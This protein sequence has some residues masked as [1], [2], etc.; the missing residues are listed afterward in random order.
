MPEPVGEIVH[1]PPVEQIH[2]VKHHDRPNISV[3]VQNPTIET[4]APTEANPFDSMRQ[5]MDGLVRQIREGKN[6]SE[7]KEALSGL[8][9]AREAYYRD[10]AMAINPNIQPVEGNEHMYQ[11]GDTKIYG[12]IT[13]MLDAT[14]SLST[15]KKFAEQI[16]LQVA[17]NSETVMGES[18][19]PRSLIESVVV[20]EGSN[21]QDRIQPF[22]ADIDMDEY[23]KIAAPDRKT[24]VHA[25]TQAL[26]RSALR[27]VITATPD[28][29]RAEMHLMHIT[30]GRHRE[31]TQAG[32]PMLW[33]MSEIQLGYK[34]LE[35]AVGKPYKYTLQEACAN[36]RGLSADYIGVANKSVFSVNK[37]I[38]VVAVD[39]NN[40]VLIDTI[41]RNSKAFQ[42]V[43]FDDPRDFHLLEHT[44]DPDTFVRY[45]DLMTNEV[46]EKSQQ[47]HLNKMKMMKRLYNLYKAKGDLGNAQELSQFFS[48]PIAAIYQL[49]SRYKLGREAVSRGIMT[50]HQ[51]QAIKENLLEVLQNQDNPLARE[52]ETLLRS[53]LI[54][55]FYEKFH[56]T[57]KQL[58]NSEIDAFLHEKPR[59]QSSLNEILGKNNPTNHN[60]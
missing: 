46:L 57:V 20:Y 32:T 19:Q 52:A 59:I 13:A 40:Q 39:S 9:K 35:D 27:P 29:Q 45:I 2:P 53:P 24:A 36:P 16:T 10:I 38:D 4:P 7:S 41:G 44:Y 60:I 48:S 56:S 5:T 21:A 12:S 49:E 25:L 26:Q 15:H 31:G 33:N 42:Q 18:L 8:L 1:M 23:V 22:A 14:P 34:M 3:E 6:V 28:G 43:F 17:G 30:L 11:V 47:S 58:I 54:H 50:G 55:G 51:R 37:L